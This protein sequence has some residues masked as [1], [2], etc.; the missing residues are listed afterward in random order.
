MGIAQSLEIKKRFPLSFFE[1]SHAND[2]TAIE[3]VSRGEAHLAIVTCELPTQS[4]LFAKPLCETEFHTYCG[5][6]HP[7]KSIAKSIIPVEKILTHPFASPNGSLFG[8]VGAKQ[9]VDG[10]R[11]DKFPRQVGFL[12]TSIKMLEELALRGQALVYL[13]DYYGDRLGLTRLKIS[14]CPYSCK[15]KVKLVRRDPRESSWLRQIF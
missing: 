13:P 1:Y 12:S 8:Q 2:Q 4:D 7:L 3:Q 9:S 5:D 11:D 10:W 14:G 15:Q 6:K